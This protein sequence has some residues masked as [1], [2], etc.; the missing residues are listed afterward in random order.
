MNVFKY[1]LKHSNIICWNRPFDSELGLMGLAHALCKKQPTTALII[2][3]S[4]LLLLNCF[5]IQFQKKGPISSRPFLQFPF[6]YSLENKHPLSLLPPSSIHAPLSLSLPTALIWNWRLKRWSSHCCL[7]T[8]FVSLGQSYTQKTYF[9]AVY[10]VVFNLCPNIY[11]LN[12][13]RQLNKRNFVRLFRV[14]WL[15]GFSF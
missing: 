2:Y 11:W 12:R 3:S 7:E 4:T 8:Y 1:V 9:S 14:L 13:L 15:M 10:F 6:L 5:L